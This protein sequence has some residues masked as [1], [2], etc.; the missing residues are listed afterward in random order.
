MS[1]LYRATVQ[2]RNGGSEYTVFFECSRRDRL[3]HLGLLMSLAWDIH[4]QNVEISNL[5]SESELLGM[6]AFSGPEGGDLRLFETGWFRGPLYA[7]PQRTLI[8][9][10]PLTAM[11]L[12]GLQQQAQQVQRIAVADFAEQA[13]RRAAGAAA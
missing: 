7:L 2:H 13:D 11:R 10:C 8:F 4:E 6:A 3:D 12:Q 1:T 9:T 5:Y